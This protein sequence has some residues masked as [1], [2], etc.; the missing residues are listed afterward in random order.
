MPVLQ[1]RKYLKSNGKHYSNFFLT[2]PIKLVERINWD[3][4]DSI[5]F[6]LKD[7]KLILE[8]IED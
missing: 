8:K 4:G 7:N 2:I 5:K 1:Q 6:R 3:E